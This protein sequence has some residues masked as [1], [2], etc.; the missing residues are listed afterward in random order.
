MNL[1]QEDCAPSTLGAANLMFLAAIPSTEKWVALSSH[2]QPNYLLKKS[3][4]P[5]DSAA[6]DSTFLDNRGTVYI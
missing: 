6:N 4:K 5:W 1:G 2:V 3:V